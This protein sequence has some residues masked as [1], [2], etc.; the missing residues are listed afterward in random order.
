MGLYPPSLPHLVIV[1]T[2]HLDLDVFSLL[3]DLA[4]T[5]IQL[6]LVIFLHQFRLQ[7][8]D[9]GRSSYGLFLKKLKGHVDGVVHVC[10]NSERGDDSGIEFVDFASDHFLSIGCLPFVPDCIG[11]IEGV[12]AAL[13]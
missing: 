5:V 6:H 9:P 4:V 13:L 12:A 11:L 7:L 2:L 10:D 1:L 3:F 8:L